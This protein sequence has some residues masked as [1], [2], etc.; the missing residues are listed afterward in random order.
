MKPSL[1]GY[2]EALEFNVVLTNIWINVLHLSVG[3]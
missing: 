3:I 2:T 1:P